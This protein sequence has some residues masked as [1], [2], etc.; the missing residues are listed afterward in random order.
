MKNGRSD[1]AFQRADGWCE[2]VCKSYVLSL[3]SRSPEI[4]FWCIG[5]PVYATYVHRGFTAS[6]SIKGVDEDGSYNEFPREPGV[7]RSR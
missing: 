7:V 1:N 4:R 6:K 3:L 5:C 2:S